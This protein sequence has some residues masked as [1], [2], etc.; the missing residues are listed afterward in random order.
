MDAS[1]A[2][3]QA[4]SPFPFELVLALCLGVLAGKERVRDECGN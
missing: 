1:D 4:P 3:L 2:H